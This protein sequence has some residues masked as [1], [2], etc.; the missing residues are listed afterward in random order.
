MTLS[1]VQ[2]SHLII[3]SCA[4]GASGWS[5]AWGAVPILGITPDTAGL[6]AISTTMGGLLAHNHDKKLSDLGFMAGGAAV[7]QYVAGALVIKMVSSA[8]PILGSVVNAMVT[9]ATVETIGWGLHLILDDDRNIAELSDDEIKKYLDRGRQMRE[10]IAHDPDLAWIHGLPRP[11]KKQWKAW[12][13]EL[14]DASTTE[15][16][17]AELLRLIEGLLG[18]YR[19]Q[20]EGE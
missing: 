10:D 3:H 18:P 4:V 20:E 7:G 16:R 6:V 5:A 19:P 1:K 11:V 17:K 15:Q 8:I 14:A 9:L 12:A 2:K 13:K